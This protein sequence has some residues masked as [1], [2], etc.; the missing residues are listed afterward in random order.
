M[1]N[2][3]HFLNEEEKKK[4]NEPSV[5]LMR[6]DFF[7]RMMSYHT[8]N[9]GATGLSMIYSMG[10][11]NGKYEVFQLRDELLELEAPITKSVLLEK[12]LQRITHMGWGSIHISEFNQI[13][14]EV[15]V[16]I[17][18]NPFRA[19]CQSVNNGGCHFL[20]GYVAGV[21]SEVLGEEVTYNE[22]RCMK[23]GDCECLLLLRKAVGEPKHPAS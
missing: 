16:E 6:T 5:V 14:S 15:K 10:F 3:T 19:K 20:Q 8:K 13:T 2:A 21:I 9:F 18:F 12:T 7:E 4:N 1:L 17:S 11:A 23:S 22:T